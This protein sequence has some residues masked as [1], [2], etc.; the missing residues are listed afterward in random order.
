MNQFHIGIKVAVLQCIYFFLATYD[1]FDDY[2]DDDNDLD[3]D[4]GERTSSHEDNS[5]S[6]RDEEEASSKPP[7]KRGRRNFITPRLVAALDKC[8][9]SNGYAV[10]LLA[11]VADALGFKIGDLVINRATIERCRKK[12]R[13]DMAEQIKADFHA[14]VI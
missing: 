1:N 13:E 11:A 7:I 2:F 9:V 8:K 14:S 6:N 5:D 3:L 10:H 4:H 12:Y